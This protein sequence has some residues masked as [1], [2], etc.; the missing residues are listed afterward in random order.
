MKGAHTA[1]NADVNIIRNQIFVLSGGD[2]K[3]RGWT[4]PTTIEKSDRGIK[5]EFTAMFLLPF[6]ERDKYLKDPSA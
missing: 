5:S 2:A 1:R 3:K 6:A 4:M